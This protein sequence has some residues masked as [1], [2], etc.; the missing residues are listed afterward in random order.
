PP[1][2]RVRPSLLGCVT[3][4]N[5]SMEELQYCLSTFIGKSSSDIE[6]STVYVILDGCPDVSSQTKSKTFKAL[7]S[8]MKLDVL[9]EVNI[10][11]EGNCRVYLGWLGFI[12]ARLY[13]KGPGSFQRSKRKSIATFY[14]ILE[15]RIAAGQS[16]EPTAV[17]HLDG[18]TGAGGEFGREPIVSGLESVAIMYRI[19]AS[20]A[21]IGAVA[22]QTR[23]FYR[24]KNMLTLM[25]S[26]DCNTT[27]VGVF[28][29]SSLVG[30]SIACFGMA[31]MY[32]YRAI[33]F[34][35][36]KNIPS[37][38]D[39]F[40]GTPSRSLVDLVNLDMN[41]DQGMTTFILRAGY[42]T[43]VSM[44]TRFY[45]FS[46]ETL[47]ELFGQR[48]RWQA[49]YFVGMP[50]QILGFPW[51]HIQA[52][53]LRFFMVVVM[54]VMWGNA[55]IL[56]GIVA[57]G[58]SFLGGAVWSVVVS[59]DVG[60]D[61]EE[62][63]EK[64]WLLLECYIAVSVWVF[65]LIFTS[66]T[67]SRAPKEIP[68]WLGFFVMGAC[69]M[70]MFWVFFAAAVTVGGRVFLALAIGL[71]LGV[72]LVLTHDLREWRHRFEEIVFY[73]LFL[74]AIQPMITMYAVA[75]IDST[76]WGTRSIGKVAAVS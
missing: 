72:G 15:K 49:G 66:K 51:P 3:A 25:Q 28:G 53:Q 9:P 63:D 32:R 20:R 58:L 33:N 65:W 34:S 8:L 37:P 13:V 74:Y 39:V 7:V 43:K 54:M 61:S 1:I 71:N 64:N 68:R 17:L 11:M 27:Y 41:E 16:R 29:G 73:L 36:V 24:R 52:T 57:A 75:N 42:E 31:V 38:L 48:R 30:R 76:L 60:G 23:V 6:V 21:N 26:F 12:P 59:S 55:F 2:C 5:E 10:M 56:P 40:S 35:R 19:M 67:I 18:D 47:A 50:S 22:S 45:T 69:V 62:G 46:P 44:I 14:Q 4:C 70:S